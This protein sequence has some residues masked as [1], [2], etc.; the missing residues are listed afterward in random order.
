M[1]MSTK[2]DGGLVFP[3]SRFEKVFNSVLNGMDSLEITHA[4]L[5]QFDLCT[6]IAMHGLIVRGM[7]NREDVLVQARQ[8]ANEFLEMKKR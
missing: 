6:L 3:G 8:F 1:S 4:G 5:T 2:D 7:N